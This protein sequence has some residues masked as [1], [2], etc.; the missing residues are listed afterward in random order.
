MELGSELAAAKQENKELRARLE[1]ALAQHQTL[2][3]Q[4]QQQQQQAAVVVALP[5]Q[6]P[7]SQ[8]QPGSSR[9]EVDG[10]RRQVAELSEKLQDYREYL[11]EAQDEVGRLQVGEGAAYQHMAPFSLP[12]C[13]LPGNRSLWLWDSIGVRRI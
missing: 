6:A 9:E 3:A 12:L 4:Q 7:G 10:L 1:Q 13:H 5:P 11:A 2:L 8:V